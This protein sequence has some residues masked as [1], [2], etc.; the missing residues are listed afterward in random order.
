[1]RFESGVRYPEAGAYFGYGELRVLAVHI[2]LR[3]EVMKRSFF[4]CL[5]VSVICIMSSFALATS[6]VVF[7]C[8]IGSICEAQERHL[9]QGFGPGNTCKVISGSGYDDCWC[10]SEPGE[11][12]CQCIGISYVS[13]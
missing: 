2:F 7:P 4:F 10:E 1:M 13:P 5:G 11:P 12:L 6:E 9:C 3:S 8:K